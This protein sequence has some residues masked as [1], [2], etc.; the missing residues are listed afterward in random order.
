MDWVEEAERE[1]IASYTTF[2]GAGGPRFWI[3]VVPEQRADDYAQLLVHTT[4]REETRHLV[5]RLKSWLPQKSERARITIEELESGPPVGVPV[6]LRL[7]GSDIEQLRELATRVK[8][9]LYSIL[10]TDNVHD[11]W[12]PEVLQVSLDIDPECASLT[13]I[14]N[15][16]IASLVQTGLSGTTSTQLR[17]QD[18]VIPVVLRLRPE[19]RSRF[20]DLMNMNAVSS[21]TNARVPLP[22]IADIRPSLASPKIRRRDHE[23][24]LTVKCDAVPGV[25]PS[26]IVEALEPELARMSFPPGY[27]YEFGGEK[28]EQ[29]K[30]FGSVAIA[31]IVSVLAIYL[32]LVLQFDSVTKPLDVYAAVPFGIVAGLMGLLWFDASFGFMAF[33]GV[34]SLAGVIVSH[35]IVLFDYIEE[36]HEKGEP[37]RR[38]VIDA[39]LVRLRPVLV[40]VLATVGGLVPLA[41]EGGRVRA[42]I[43]SENAATERALASYERSFLQAL[44]EVEDA[45]VAYARELERHRSL[46][47]AAQASRRA[48]KL[49]RDLYEG[50]LTTFLDTLDAERV[51]YQAESR[52]AQSETAIATDLVRL[53]KSLGGGWNLDPDT[54]APKVA[55]A[56]R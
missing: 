3:S 40:T 41:L 18:R 19:E 20:E 16:D 44:T 50:G 48:A 2:V 30:G 35:V 11:D 21:L 28:H 55:L 8:H 10:G 17:E 39:A 9:V 29:A 46:E 22:Q 6:Q 4:E 15:E 27:R 34:A 5:Q 36:M 38:A 7:F 52:L 32:A 13:G 23:R 1:H 24:C 26:R 54:G 45:L 56:G 33:L 51:S 25:L 31:L 37:V 14:T 47:E 53:Y 12:D 49:A 42:R 43:A